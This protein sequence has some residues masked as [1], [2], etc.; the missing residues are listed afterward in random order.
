MNPT[1]VDIKDILESISSLALVYATNLFI[2]KE[3]ASPVD[4]VT[5]FDTAGYGDEILLTGSENGNAY[6]HTAVQIRVRNKKYILGWQVAEN[7][8]YQLHGRAQETWNSALYSAVICSS[9]PAL[10]DWDDNAN[11]RFIINFDIQRRKI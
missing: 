6:Q 1:S 2:G 3:P 8:K 9:G 10:M 4:T 11:A 7:I 5:I